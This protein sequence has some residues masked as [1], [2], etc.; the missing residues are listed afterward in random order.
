MSHLVLPP[1]RRELYA[2]LCFRHFVEEIKYLP[3]LRRVPKAHPA[4]VLV[5][6]VIA[7]G[8]L[9]ELFKE[10][11][12]ASLHCHG[13]IITESVAGSVTHEVRNSVAESAFL[14]GSECVTSKCRFAH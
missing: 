13:L 4:K 10:L 2:S 3:D 6:D 12:S 8:Y 5:A 9:V 1:K 11:V 7:D 14:A